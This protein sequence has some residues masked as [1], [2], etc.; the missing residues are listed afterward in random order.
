MAL[1][2]YCHKRPVAA[3]PAVAD[4]EMDKLFAA[5]RHTE[6]RRPML[7]RLHAVPVHDD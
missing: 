6:R 1:L 3:K 7:G 2:P 4:T 5:V